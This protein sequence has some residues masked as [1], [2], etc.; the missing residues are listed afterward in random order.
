MEPTRRRAH[1]LCIYYFESKYIYVR[2]NM[3]L[4]RTCGWACERAVDAHANVHVHARCSAVREQSGSLV[5]ISGK[6]M[7]NEE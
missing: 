6:G 2:W 1:I 5:V 7:G 4:T 3:C